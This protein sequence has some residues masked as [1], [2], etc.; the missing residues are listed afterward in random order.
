MHP[1]FQNTST[2][3]TIF[4]TQYSTVSTKALERFLNEQYGFQEMSCRLLIRNVSDT[5]LLE[6]ESE[7][8]IFKIYRNTHRNLSEIKAEVEL[9]HHLKQQG[10][11]VAFPIFDKQGNDIQSFNVAEGVRYGVLFTYALGKPVY[12]LNEHQLLTVGREMA[13]NHNISSKVTLSHLR[14]K[15]DINTTLLTPLEVIKPAFKDLPE[16]YE[17]LR[18]TSDK[19]IAKLD[20]FDTTKFSYGYCHYD[21]LPKNFHFDENDNITFFD[22]DFASKGFLVND[23][24]TF[25]VHFF[26]HVHFKAITQE[27]ADKDFDT[28][29][30]GY[31]ENRELS[32]E[33]IATIPYL[34]FMFWMYYFKFQFE[35]FEDWSNYFFTPRFIKE[36]V[37]LIKKWT[38]LYCKF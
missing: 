30:K 21:Y 6:G 23:V 36:R 10:A 3:N 32:D 18:V 25:F 17:Y 8:Y 34:G 27:Q 29:L 26:F 12:D 33:E 37:T 19:V 11:K 35:H 2:M 24:M 1:F 16:E 9:L 4:P 22:F 7:K 20:E 14:E 5:Y 28:F 13:I 15:L 38:D 31:R